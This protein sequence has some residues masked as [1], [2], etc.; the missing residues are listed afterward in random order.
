M[1]KQI[2]ILGAT[3]MLGSMVLDVF[4][5]DNDFIVTATAR[6]AKELKGVQKKY[7]RI[8]TAILDV[9]FVSVKDLKKA[10][11]KPDWIIN[12][13]GIIKPYIHDDNFQE[14]ERA[15]RINSLFPHA[16]AKA[17][18]ELKAKVLQIETDCVYSGAKGK[19]KETDPHD[20]WDVYGKTKSLGETYSE[21]VFHLRNSIIGPEP[22]AHVSL[23]DWFLGQPKNARA[24]GFSNHYWNGITTLHFAKICAGIIKKN[25]KFPRLRHVIPKDI[26]SKERLLK[27]F[28]RYFKREDIK[29]KS[30]RAPNKVNRT[31][32]TENPELNQQIWQAAGYVKIPSVQ[33][34]VKELSE[35][36][37]N[38]QQN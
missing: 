20:A 36:V 18:E 32:A 21:N 33:A 9:E 34:M 38:G 10:L 26:V 15:I 37:K 2:C 28:S 13:I 7:P 3:G 16:L 12:C 27:I 30:V 24:N 6:S 5:K 8:K 14:I 31:L 11:K 23:L 17:A 22:S 19:Y 35:Y 29:I 1:K 4:V 25:L